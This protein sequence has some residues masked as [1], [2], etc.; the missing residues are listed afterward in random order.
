MSQGTERYQRQAAPAGPR[1]A[2]K[3]PGIEAQG[4]YDDGFSWLWRLIDL[5][6]V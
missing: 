4:F 2:E 6:W 3:D 1:V 5:L